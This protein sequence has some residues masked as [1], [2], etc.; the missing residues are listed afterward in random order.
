MSSSAIKS[1]LSQSQEFRAAIFRKIK[2]IPFTD[3]NESRILATL[4]MLDISSE[5]WFSIQELIKNEHF[6]S[7]TALMRLQY[8]SLLRGS[9]LYW[10]ADDKHIQSLNQALN[11]QNVKKVER[12]TPTISVIL[13]NLKAKVETGEIP[14]KFFSL[15]Q[16]F[17]EQHLKPVHSFVHS[18]MHAFNRKKEGYI[19]PMIIQIGQN[20]NGLEVLNAMLQAT[21]IND[22]EILMYIVQMQ[23]LYLNCLPMP[24]SDIV[25]TFYS[26]D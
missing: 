6:I 12:S 7:S 15:V 18:G 4:I 9:W 19:D 3:E 14:K 10:C 11:E 1:F 25:K 16:E 21:L 20:A 2:E 22:G 23:Y 8:E 26:A 5:H 24:I 13:E 17:K